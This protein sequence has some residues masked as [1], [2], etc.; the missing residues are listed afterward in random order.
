[1][2][3]QELPERRPTK[4]DLN[5]LPSEYLPKKTSKLTIILAIAVVVL[6]CA[7]WPF[8]IMKSGVDADN[9]VLE[10]EFNSLDT[11]Y[12]T[13][14]SQVAEC[15]ALDADI[16]NIEAEWQLMLSDWDTF[17]NSIR[18]WSEIFYDVMQTPR[19][20]GGMLETITQKAE[21]ISV[22]GV[23]NRERYIYEY[24]VMLSETGHFIEDGINIKSI[25]LS[26][27]DERRFKIEAI[28]KPVEGD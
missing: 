4:I 26:S 17:Q 8:L 18:V 12:K 16:E 28:L 24:S 25:T 20:A 5:L 19:G 11:Q 10:A 22:D 6:A 14:V 15:N 7:P 13:L 2:T 23:F 3:M 9:R 27:E 21:V 1:M